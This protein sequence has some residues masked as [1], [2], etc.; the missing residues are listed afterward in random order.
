M[1][2]RLNWSGCGQLQRQLNLPSP[3]EESV[4]CI[5]IYLGHNSAQSG[6]VV[7]N[8]LSYLNCRGDLHLLYL[9]INRENATWTYNDANVRLKCH[10]QRS[11]TN[12]VEFN[13]LSHLSGASY[14][15]KKNGLK[16]FQ[17]I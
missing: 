4:S 8:W 1:G 9:S 5:S 3:S 17:S 13:R 14:L 6:V 16:I 2:N 10:T 11:T 12:T 15:Q 7:E